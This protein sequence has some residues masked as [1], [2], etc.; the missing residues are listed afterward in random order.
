M[1]FENY[2]ARKIFLGPLILT[3]R[4]IINFVAVFNHAE[5]DKHDYVQY[6][7]NAGADNG[8]EDNLQ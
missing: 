1:F 5:N 6:Y 3:A 4:T 8:D 7:D 2:A